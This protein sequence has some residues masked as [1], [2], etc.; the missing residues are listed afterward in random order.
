MRAL[1]DV[2]WISK[3]KVQGRHACALDA[4]RANRTATLEPAGIRDPGGGDCSRATPLPTTCNSKP[5][6]W[7]NCTAARNGLP[8]NSGTT[9]PDETSSTTV[10]EGCGTSFGGG[11]SKGAVLSRT[12]A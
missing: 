12:T 3:S 9:W 2:L 4:Q 10:P 5:D 7:A 1:A 8:T 11:S 6:C